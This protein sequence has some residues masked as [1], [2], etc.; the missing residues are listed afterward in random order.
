[1][2]TK[3]TRSAFVTPTMDRPELHEQM[4][5]VF[6][7]QLVSP[8][9]LY[10]LDESRDPSPFFSRPREDAVYVH[11]PVPPRIGGVTTIGRARNAL[12]AMV[13]DGATIFHWDDDDWYAP[14]YAPTMLGRIGGAAL[15]KMDVYRLHHVHTGTIFEWD[16]RRA[17]GHHYALMGSIVEH[18]DVPRGGEVMIGQ[19]LREGFGFS[20]VYPKSTWTRHPFPLEGTEDIPFARAI[21]EGGG[22][23]EFVSDRPEMVL[24]A[25][26]PKSQSAVY[27]QTF[28]ARHTMIGAGL[29]LRDSVRAGMIGKMSTELP[30]GEPISVVPGVDYTVLVQLKDSHSIRDLTV[31]AASWGVTITSARDNVPPSEFGVDKPPG[32]YRLVLVQ[33][34]SSKPGKLPWAVPAPLSVFDKTRCVRAWTSAAPMVGTLRAMPRTM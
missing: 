20:Y 19:A 10:V 15:A 24:H 3:V 23:I 33:A 32:G 16:S 2:P 4:Y 14:D 29:S 8:K 25:V 9:T 31:R 7:S 21:R 1:M 17:G 11:R 18:V 6:R 27:P 28:V 5:G 22:R 12:N 34:N 26:H 30:R 13:P